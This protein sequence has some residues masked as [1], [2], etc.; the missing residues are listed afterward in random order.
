MSKHSLELISISVLKA[1]PTES[2]FVRT[3][4]VT[5]PNDAENWM[6]GW[7]DFMPAIHAVSSKYCSQ[8]GVLNIQC[9][10]QITYT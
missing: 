8:A 1:K 2:D 10:M 4:N 3:F 5:M 7:S 6:N 9:T